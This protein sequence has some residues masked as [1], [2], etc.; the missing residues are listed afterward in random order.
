MNRLPSACVSAVQV[1][2]DIEKKTKAT[3]IIVNL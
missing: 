1:F 2:A 3:E